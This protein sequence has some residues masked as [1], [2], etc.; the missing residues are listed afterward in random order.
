MMSS[1]HLKRGLTEGALFFFNPYF[2]ASSVKSCCVNFATRSAVSWHCFRCTDCCGPHF[3]CPSVPAPP[4]TC[5]TCGVTLPVFG[6]SRCLREHFPVSE[7][8]WIKLPSLNTSAKFLNLA[9]CSLVCL[10]K[11]CCTCVRGVHGR[12]C[13]AHVANACAIPSRA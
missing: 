1:F 6:P 7:V 11:R 5:L 8:G 4:L 9:A 13:G 12:W 3:P 2:F 10:L